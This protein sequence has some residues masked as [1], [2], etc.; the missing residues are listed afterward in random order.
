MKRKTSIAAAAAVV[1]LAGTGAALGAASGGGGEARHGPGAPTATAPVERGDLSDS[2]SV[3]GTLGYGGERKLLA[4][5]GGVVT[6][7]RGSGSTVR[8]DEEVY[9]VQGHP[10]R[11]MYGTRPMYRR[12]KTGDRGPDV[13]QLERD[14][15]ALGYGD[16]LTVDRSFTAATADAVKRWQ[17]HHHATATGTLGPGD[18]VFAPGPVLI[19]NRDAATGERVAPGGPIVT[20][21]GTERVVDLKLTIDEASLV[22]KGT[23]VTVELPGGRTAKGTVRSIGTK[24]IKDGEDGDQGESKINVLVRLDD[25]GRA[26]RLDQAPVTVDL[27]TQTKKNVLSVPVQALLALP[28][29]GYGVRV[30]DGGAPRTVQVELGIF[31][32]GRVEVTGGGLSEGMKVQVAAS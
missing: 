12:L 5:A 15:R 1:V 19:T 13:R 23:K 25:P 31:G 11:L 18:I 10:V 7:V 22:K 26:G 24:A 3:D 6:W 20:C 27:T 32:Q 4:G 17:R 8:M 28:G 21:A 14:L 30:V 9:E 16:G 2:T 29:G